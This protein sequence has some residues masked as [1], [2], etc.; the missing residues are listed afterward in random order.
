M[1]WQYMT[2]SLHVNVFFIMSFMRISLCGQI[3][4]INMWPHYCTIMIA[5]YSCA[6]TQDPTI[7]IHDPTSQII[8]L[9]PCLL[10]YGSSH[11]HWLTLFKVIMKLNMVIYIVLMYSCRIVLFLAINLAMYIIWPCHFVFIFAIST[12]LINRVQLFRGIYPI[13]GALNGCKH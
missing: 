4:L 1:V 13:W 2:R 9:L 7:T 5:R 6:I 3:E 10:I 11:C 8:A 12:T